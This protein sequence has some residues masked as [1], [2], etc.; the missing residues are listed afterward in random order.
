MANG[1]WHSGLNRVL[2]LDKEDLGLP[3][4]SDINAADLVAEL[5]QPVADRA[6]TLLV[7]VESGQ[8]KQCKA[9]LNGVKSPYMYVRRHRGPDGVIRLRAAHLPTVHEMTVE[10]SDRHKAMKDF[11][12][13]TAQAAGLEAHIEKATKFRTSRP[14]VTVIGAG[15]LNLGCE[16]QYYNASAGTVLRRSRAHSGAG[17]TPNWITH[18]D[19]FHLV[20]RA[21]WMLT[22]E[23]TWRELSNAADL[24]L[25]GGY[26]VLAEWECTASAERPCPNGL[27]KT[28]CGRIHL[29]WDTPRRLDDEGTGW[30]GWGGN[31]RGVTLGQVLVGAATGSVL[32]LFVPSRKDARAGSH[33]WVPAEDLATWS[34]YRSVDKPGFEDGED[35]DDEVRF[36]GRDAETGCQFGEE[37]WKPSARLR[38]RGGAELLITVDRPR[39]RDGQGMPNVVVP[40]QRVVLD[41]SDTQSHWRDVSQPCRYCRTPTNLVDE[42]SVPSHKECAEKNLPNG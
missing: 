42:H 38:R 15:G 20:D 32:S 27:A 8:G 3:P 28:G 5:L 4:G 36:S 10:E 34:E 26:R 1:V 37:S 2:E 9:E 13:R 40:Q 6:R 19:S 24:P 12:A 21:N 23:A 18:D 35:V 33:M 14:D 30:T 22:R 39:Q 31:S 25:V 7:C 11:V 17:L 41:W 16:A 29:Q